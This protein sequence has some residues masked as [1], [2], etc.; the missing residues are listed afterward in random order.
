MTRAI[1]RTGVEEGLD[2]EGRWRHSDVGPGAVEEAGQAQVT[3]LG[4]RT[5]STH[6]IGKSP[7]TVADGVHDRREEATGTFGPGLGI[8]GCLCRRQEREWEDRRGWV[9]R[10]DEYS[11][12]QVRD[13]W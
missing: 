11:A 5:D 9:G 8:S 13:V 3:V 12:T 4:V 10:D 1:T 7:R 2:T 6:C